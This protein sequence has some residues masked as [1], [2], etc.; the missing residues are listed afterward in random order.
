MKYFILLLLFFTVNQS[1]AQSNALLL[2]KKHFDKE[3]KDWA[4]TFDS[5][6][7]SDFAVQDTSAFENNYPQDLQDYS[8]FL[9]TYKPI[10]T[11]TKDSSKFIDIY[12][13]QLNIEKKGNAYYANPDVD[14]AILLCD[15]KH[16][17]WDRIVFGAPG[18]YYTEA[19]WL[20]DSTFL[21]TGDADAGGNDLKRIPVIL[22]GN[23]ITQKLI[24]YANHNTHCVK[25]RDYYSSK[26]KR[27]RIKG[28]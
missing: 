18:C 23:T 25:K 15:R 8:S 28:L 22:F 1:Q 24:Y 6:H 7:L 14:Q 16:K 26:L 19:T 20:S 17:Y 4:N 13:Y 21:L 11:F 2:Q 5:F 9:K 27:I 10:M 12:S 3:L